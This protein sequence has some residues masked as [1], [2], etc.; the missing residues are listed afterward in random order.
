MYQFTKMHK[1]THFPLGGKVGQLSKKKRVLCWSIFSL[2][3][4]LVSC[5]PCLSVVP[6]GG[7]GG[8]RGVPQAAP[9]QGQELG[10]LPV[11]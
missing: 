10:H 9:V 11:Q 2:V 1:I 5:S 6:P 3:S 8:L 4:C 7:G